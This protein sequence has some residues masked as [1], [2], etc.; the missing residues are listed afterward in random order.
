[1]DQ[2]T[3]LAEWQVL[4]RYTIIQADSLA[5]GPILPFR[6]G[7]EHV[8]E[9]RMRGRLREKNPQSGEGIEQ[10]KSGFIYLSVRISLGCLSYFSNLI[11]ISST[12]ICL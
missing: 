11:A 6:E 5:I 8:D 3:N 2:E 1:M 9:S 12:V 7:I 4:S 10:T